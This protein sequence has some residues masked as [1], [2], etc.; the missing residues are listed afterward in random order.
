MLF[1]EQELFN[2]KAYLLKM[3]KNLLYVLGSGSCLA[4]LSWGGKKPLLREMEYI[5][6]SEGVSSFQ[7]TVLCW[8]TLLILDNVYKCGVQPRIV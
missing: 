2:E 6:S 1:S 7:H 4:Q 3:Q 5:S 8:F